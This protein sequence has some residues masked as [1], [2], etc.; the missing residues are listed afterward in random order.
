MPPLH[1]YP[2]RCAKLMAKY[3]MFIL[4]LCSCSDSSSIKVSSVHQR[5]SSQERMQH[6]VTKPNSLQDILTGADSVVIASHYSPNEPIED[7][8]TG[9]LLPRFEVVEDDKLNEAIVQERKKL[10]RK[11]IKELESILTT[12]AIAD[13]IAAM[14]FQ[15]R[16]GVF[17]YKGD[18][19]SYLDVC[20]DCHGYAASEDIGSVVT[21]NHPKYKKLLQFFRKHGFRYM[22]D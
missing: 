5:D 22:L 3:L 12:A 8:R 16:N 13:S 4:I 20:F 6:P 18:R 1:K 11:D 21:M 17:V 15:P 7:K 14:C 2:F 19:L 9:K 10:N